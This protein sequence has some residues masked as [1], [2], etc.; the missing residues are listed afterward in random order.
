VVATIDTMVE[1]RDFHLDWPGFTFGVLG[2]RLMSV[3]LSD[4]AAMGAEPG[5]ALLSLALPP[6]LDA[7]HLRSLY[8]GLADRARSAGCAI[9]GGD[10]SAT[11]GPMVL[12]LALFGRLPRG[13]RPLRRR[14]AHAGWTVAVTGVLGRAAA[15]L[16]LLLDGRGPRTAAERRWVS[17]LYDPPVRLE[18]AR[19]LQ[20]AGARVAGDVSDGLYRELQRIAEPAR[21]GVEVE[22]ERLPLDADL[23]RRGRRA[24]TTDLYESEDYEL[25]CAAPARVITAAGDRMWSELRLKLTPIGRL[26]ASR[27]MRVRGPKGTVSIPRARAGYDHFS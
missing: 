18:A 10:L 2:R 17:A 9:A 26:T 14:G 16:R 4:L 13:R 5:H 8:R 20:A 27:G 3:N 12:T 6:R 25:V 22:A 23:R 15:G 1:G 24:W 7:V 11:G 19:I 21:L